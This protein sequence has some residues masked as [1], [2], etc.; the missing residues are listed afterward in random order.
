[1]LSKKEQTRKKK[2]RDEKRLQKKELEKYQFWLKEN[3]PQCQAQLNGCE[4]ETI[5]AHHVLFG[6]FGAD[7]DD[8]TVI[9]VCRS[10][11]EFCHKNKALSKELFL[12]VAREN[13]KQYGG[14]E[15]E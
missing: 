5:E 14:C 3:Y 12:H 2:M 6:S 8:K 1:M 11:H 15:D 7:K 13:W 10:C 4:H 9:A